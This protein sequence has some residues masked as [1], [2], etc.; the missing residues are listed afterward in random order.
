MTYKNKIMCFS[1]NNCKYI[2]ENKLKVSPL[3]ILKTKFLFTITLITLLTFSCSGED[4][5]DGVNG[6]QGEQGL[7]G[8]DGFDGNANVKTT[9]LTNTDW[10]CCEN[11]RVSTSSSISLSHFL[12]M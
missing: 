7:A 11:Y 3:L 2:K 1:K 5:T 4:G 6:L 8:L 9:S 12:D 10:L